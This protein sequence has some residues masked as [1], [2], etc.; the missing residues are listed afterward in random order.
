MAEGAQLIINGDLD[1]YSFLEVD[2]KDDITIIRRQYR[3]KAL[4][5]HPDKSG[6]ANKFNLLNTV[7]NVLTTESLRNQY[8]K[9]RRVKLQKLIEQ[10]Q[11]NELT[12]R[13]Q[14]ELL[15]AERANNNTS[16]KRNLNLEQLRE[17]GI[18]KR[19]LH[20][21][22]FVSE[23]KDYISY[24]DLPSANYISPNS[25]S[26]EAKVK[27]KWK[28]KPELAGQFQHDVLQMIMEIF[29]SVKSVEILPHRPN[30]R[31][32]TGLIEYDLI[33]GLKKACLHDFRKS[34]ELWDGTPVRRLASLMREC[35]EVNKS[36]QI[37]EDIIKK[38]QENRR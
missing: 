22:Q 23:N 1:L 3:K 30:S 27:V 34:A 18:K 14:Q 6:D 15:Q 38:Y 4:I 20:E 35:Q 10:E 24:Q 31:Y 2:H 32:D 29:G 9:I 25:A 8:D 26:N 12:K 5:Y 13:F 11:L 36:S 19:R 33:E 28:Y 7:Y 17:D 37:I 16:T 21:L